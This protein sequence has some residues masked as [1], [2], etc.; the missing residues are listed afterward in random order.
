MQSQLA[1]AN[2]QAS[3]LQRTTDALNQELDTARAEAHQL[4]SQLAALQR[5][6][7]HD[8]H[9]ADAAFK[10]DLAQK[11]RSWKVAMATAVADH[12]AR[13][14]ALRKCLRAEVEAAAKQDR[15]NLEKDSNLAM[16][17]QAAEWQAKVSELHAEHA[18][19][20][21]SQAAEFEAKHAEQAQQASAE[22]QDSLAAGVSQLRQ[23]YAAAVAKQVQ[24]SAEQLAECKQR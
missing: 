4:Q 13:D 14:E 8:M 1:S 2:S 7:K 18:A 16:T 19:A 20:L 24:Q 5:Q 21:A 22:A 12:T 15:E 6:S 11:E 10:S 9:A 23:E 17:Q 3:K